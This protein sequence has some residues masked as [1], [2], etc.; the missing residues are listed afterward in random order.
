MKYG[1]EV[2]R[3]AFGRCP[4]DRSD[5]ARPKPGVPERIPEPFLENPAAYS[6]DGR[7]IVYVTGVLG[8]PEVLVRPF[9]G[10]GG[11]WQ[12]SIS[13]ACI[14]AFQSRSITVPLIGGTSES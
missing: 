12:I 2:R 9:P 10:P 3:R 5:G 14:G 1:E 7:W 8:I 11:P 13:R 4:L 6:P